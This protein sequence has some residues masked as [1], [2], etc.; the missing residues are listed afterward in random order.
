MNAQDLGVLIKKK[1][2]DKNL[3]QKQLGELL[4]VSLTTVS[5]WETGINFPD[6]QN[7]KALSNLLDIPIFQVFDDNPNESDSTVP[8]AP[9]IPAQPEIL[10]PDPPVTPKTPTCPISEP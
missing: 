6:I 3:T 9:G 10:I 7:L 5:K 2:K 8:S 4:H 1:R